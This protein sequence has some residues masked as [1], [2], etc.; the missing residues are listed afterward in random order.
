[1]EQL[2][3]TAV[4]GRIRLR[5][6]R[7]SDIDRLHL[8]V[9]DSLVHLRPW[10]PWALQDYTRDSAI[11]FITDS[12]QLWTTGDRYDYAVVV[13]DELA[14][15]CG[16]HRRIG[17]GGLEIGYWL[18]PAYTGQGIATEAVTALT[19]LAFALPDIDHLQIWHDAAN[20]ASA[21]IPRRLGFTE[22]D[23]RTPPREPSVPGRLGVDVIWQL[24]R[25]TSTDA[26]R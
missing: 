19:A 21:G 11:A 16:L 14:G 5:R 15:G 12:R 3:E 8:A 13:N 23:R 18:H 17:E 2:A 24:T 26:E 22:I 1:V 25:D 9:N 20:T 6:W 7:D 4:R 10:I